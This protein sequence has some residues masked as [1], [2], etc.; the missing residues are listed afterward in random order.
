MLCIFEKHAH[1]ED[2]SSKWYFVA[3]GPKT[4]DPAL[5]FGTA[6]H[7]CNFDA[8]CCHAGL[9]SVMGAG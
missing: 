9:M 5:S 6:L 4:H 7:A 8:P 1:E 3:V 2:Q